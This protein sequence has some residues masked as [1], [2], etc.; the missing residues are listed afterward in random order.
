MEWNPIET[1]PKDRPFL[2]RGR[3]SIGRPMIPVVVMWWKPDGKGAL[4]FNDVASGKD[5]SDMVSYVALNGKSADWCELP[6]W[7]K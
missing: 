3:N 6:D 7:S 1:L 4:G 2:L 5:M